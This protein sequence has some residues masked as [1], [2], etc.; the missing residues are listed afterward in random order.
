MRKAIK[1]FEVDEGSTTNLW[2][3]IRVFFNGKLVEEFLKPTMFAAR[4][5]FEKAGYKLQ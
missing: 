1:E 2:Y 4:R 3:R 5:A